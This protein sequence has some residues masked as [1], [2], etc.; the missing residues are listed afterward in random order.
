MTTEGSNDINGFWDIVENDL[1]KNFCT[2]SISIYGPI[3]YGLLSDIVDY[4]RQNY[5][6]PK[7]L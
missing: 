5:E 4:L 3:D 6:P 2:K 7:K 1:F